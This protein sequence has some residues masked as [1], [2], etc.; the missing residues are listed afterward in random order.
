MFVYKCFN[1]REAW[2]RHMDAPV[3]YCVLL[4]KSGTDNEGR[5]FL[6]NEAPTQISSQLK[7][8]EQSYAR[9]SLCALTIW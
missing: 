5:Y 2:D 4:G 7:Y 6:D 9:F 3:F 8:L 1:T